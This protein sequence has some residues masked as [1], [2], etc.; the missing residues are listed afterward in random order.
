MSRSHIF[1]T[2]LGTAFR[3]PCLPSLVWRVVTVYGG[4]PQTDRPGRRPGL[5][6]WHER[7]AKDLQQASIGSPIAI[8]QLAEERRHLPG[9]LTRAIRATI[10]PKAHLWLVTERSE[11]S[12]DLLIKRL[13]SIRAVALGAGFA[14]PNHM[15]RV[16][17]RHYGIA[18]ATYCR[19][20]GLSV[21]IETASAS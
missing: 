16:F 5:A 19:H 18:S 3:L 12:R 17:V 9:H 6:T 11:H 8:A 21:Q 2:Q 10:E 1:G 15:I 13:V 7:R 14:N 4:S 20:R